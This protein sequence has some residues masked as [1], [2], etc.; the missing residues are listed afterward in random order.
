M[1]ENRKFQL[2]VDPRQC[3]FGKWYYSFQTDNL[4]LKSYLRRFEIPHER[5]HRVGAEAVGLVAE[6]RQEQALA[7]IERTRS[8]PLAEVLT[9]F[10][11]FQEEY[12]RESREVAIVMAHGGNPFAL[13]ADSVVSLEHVRPADSDDIRNLLCGLSEKAVLSA[14]RRAKNNDLVLLLNCDLLMAA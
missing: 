14:A 1:R 11:R 12:E 13:V 6:G 5:I 8:G 3:A 4:S 7:L 9:L 2:A 10:G